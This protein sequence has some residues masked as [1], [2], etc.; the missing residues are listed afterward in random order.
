LPIA[1]AIALGAI[2]APPDAVAANE[3]QLWGSLVFG[4]SVFAIVIVVRIACPV[5]SDRCHD[6]APE[7]P[8]SWDVFCQPKVTGLP[9]R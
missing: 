4:L 2:V 5:Q 7:R 3:E 8:F 1:A 6:P 9:L